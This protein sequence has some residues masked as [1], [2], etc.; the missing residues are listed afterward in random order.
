MPWIRLATRQLHFPGGTLLE[1]G[2]AWLPT[3]PPT[4][5]SG[6]I[7]KSGVKFIQVWLDVNLTRQSLQHLHATLLERLATL[8]RRHRVH[9]LAVF[10]S[11]ARDEARTGSDYDFLVAFDALPSGGY[12]T[13]LFGLQEDLQSLS[14]APVEMAVDR[15]IRNP[16]LRQSV[17]ARRRELYAA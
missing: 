8:C 3:P 5:V 17:Q 2:L 15:A 11:M 6:T 9:R 13:A 16:H 10:G 12:A 14:E 1:S 4:K 7:G